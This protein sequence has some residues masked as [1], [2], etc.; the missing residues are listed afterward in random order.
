M[1]NYAKTNIG[2]EQ[3][4]IGNTTRNGS[5]ELTIAA[6]ALRFY[7]L[8]VQRIERETT[9]IVIV[10]DVVDHALPP[11]EEPVLG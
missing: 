3:H 9:D 8:L 6:E 5:F 2:N 11:S 10:L 4:R 1:A 7:A